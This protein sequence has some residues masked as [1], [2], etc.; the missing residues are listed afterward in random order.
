[1]RKLLYN[2]DK[3]ALFYD[4]ESAVFI[5]FKRNADINDKGLGVSTKEK[6]K[7]FERWEKIN[8]LLKS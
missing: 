5:E 7:W 3:T 1:M 8:L 4:E 2:D 6:P